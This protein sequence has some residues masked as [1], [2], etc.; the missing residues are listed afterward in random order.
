MISF[1]IGSDM[2]FWVNKMGSSPSQLGPPTVATVLK[3]G[4][5]WCWMRRVAVKWG[6]VWRL[7]EVAMEAAVGAGNRAWARVASLSLR[8]IV[9]AGPALLQVRRRS[10]LEASLEALGVFSVHRGGRDTG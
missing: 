2:V 6:N 7:T 9:H 8:P 5:T 10:L 3:D 1:S 4:H